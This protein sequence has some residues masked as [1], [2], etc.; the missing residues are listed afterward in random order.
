MVRIHE[1]TN[2]KMPHRKEKGFTNLHM[3]KFL[4]VIS[5]K[6]VLIIIL[7]LIIPSIT[8]MRVL[9]VSHRLMT[10]S[11]QNQK[12]GG[13]ILSVVVSTVEHTVLVGH[14]D[15]DVGLHLRLRHTRHEKKETRVGSLYC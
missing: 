7:P 10:K 9:Y 11:L 12:R 8:R 13:D 2:G 6:N 1:L 15:R 14:R 3:C 4:L 5:K